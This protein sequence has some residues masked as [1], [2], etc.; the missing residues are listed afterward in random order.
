[1]RSRGAP[2][3]GQNAFARFRTPWDGRRL[4]Q[5]AGALYCGLT[6]ASCS[7]THRT[8]S[9]T[10]TLEIDDR[11]GCVYVLGPVAGDSDHYYLST[12][13]TG[14]TAGSAEINGPAGVRL[15]EGDRLT[16]TGELA[17]GD[18]DSV[19]ENFHKFFVVTTIVP[20]GS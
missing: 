10:G 5:L 6:L 19:C 2:Q 4:V 9:V 11:N 3:P 18:T 8:A 1:V 17:G 13:P 20:A 12:L 15:A 7:L 16:V 14:Y